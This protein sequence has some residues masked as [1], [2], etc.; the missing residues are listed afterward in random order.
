[1]TTIKWVFTGETSAGKSTLLN[2]LVGRKIFPVSN[3]AA[4]G[5]VC[6]VRNSDTLYVK[7]YDRH[8]NLINEEI[9]TSEQHLTEVIIRYSDT[10]RTSAETGNVFYVDV[11]MPVE[12]LKASDTNAHFSHTT[13]RKCIIVFNFQVPKLIFHSI[14]W[15]QCVLQDIHR[16]NKTKIYFLT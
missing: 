3:V 16:Y 7:T 10:N 6:R 8:E 14:N 2:T 12:F 15:F 13:T 11:H 5:K 1:M 9:A 4:T